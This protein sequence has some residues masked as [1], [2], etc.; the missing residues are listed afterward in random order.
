M[1]Q[2]AIK[3]RLGLI[4]QGVLG[5]ILT[6][7]GISYA[8]NVQYD[9]DCE[10]PDFLIP[11]A[12]EP[13]FVVEIHQTDARDSFCMKTLRAFTAVAEAKAHF[14]EDLVSVNVLFSDPQSELP[15]ANVRALFGF[16]DVNFVPRN[17]AQN[18][19]AVV[20]LEEEALRLA[21]PNDCAVTE[22]IAT[23]CSS[24]RAGIEALMPWARDTFRD[25]TM[26]RPELIPMWQMEGQRVENLGDSPDVGSNTYYKRAILW[27]LF[28]SDEQFQELLTVP[29]AIDYSNALKDQ[30]ILTKLGEERRSL[31]GRDVELKP[32]FIQFLCDPEAARLRG[33]CEQRLEQDEAMRWFFEDIRNQ[34][35]R[36]QM[37][38]NFFKILDS[39]SQD[40]ISSSVLDNLESNSF[41]DINHNRC[42]IVDLIARYLGVSHNEFNRQITSMNCDYQDLR[43]P[44]N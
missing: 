3:T 1:S 41:H 28:V 7:A 14:G 25:S 23:L 5:H 11:N 9:A 20:A 2:T 27:S 37:A 40:T 18:A 6:Q 36:N 31:R 42:W 15:E 38:E 16:F 12:E 34:E 43:N 30:L 44:F 8:E 10:T 17:I 35:R 33:L 39:E 29:N 26:A 13:R 21:T 4:L 32:E 22:A 24:H 19:D